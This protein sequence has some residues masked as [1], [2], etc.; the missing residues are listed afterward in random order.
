M[1]I[2]FIFPNID[3]GGYKP[4]GLTSVMN[5]VRKAGYDVKLF[6]TSFLDTSEIIENKNYKGFSSAGEEILNFKPVDVSNL[7]ILQEKKDVSTE[8][9]KTIQDF[10]PDI[11]WISALSVEWKLTKYLFRVVKEFCPSIVTVLGGIHTFADPLGSFEEKGDVGYSRI[12]P[13]IYNPNISNEEY[14]GLIRTFYL[15]VKFLEKV[16]K[17]IKKAEKFDK[18]GNEVYRKF[19]KIYRE[20][21]LYNMVVREE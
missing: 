17:E 5:S 3:C 6:D 18:E 2:L 11:V 19:A 1:K 10:Q 8:L 14:R 4:V 21:E 16:W 9:R 12:Y 15:Y 7:N 13:A 20:E